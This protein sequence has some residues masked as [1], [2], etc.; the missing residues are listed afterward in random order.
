ML[1][2]L[3]TPVAAMNGPVPP[4]PA[5]DFVLPM[6]TSYAETVAANRKFTD[7]SR[8][9]RLYEQRVRDG[10]KGLQGVWRH[11]IGIVLLLATVIL[12]TA[13]NFLASVS[14]IETLRGLNPADMSTADHL[15]R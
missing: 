1:S 8:S 15:R 10:Q 14:G 13:S 5:D 4:V 7:S 3:G 2:T 12:W 11:T 9:Q 6:P